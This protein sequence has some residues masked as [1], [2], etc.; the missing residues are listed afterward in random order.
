MSRTLILGLGNRLMT[1]DAVGLEALGA[2]R[3]KYGVPDGVDLMDGGT[4]GLDLLVHLEGY[5]RVLILDSVCTGRAPGD[6]VRVDG[7]AI[8]AVFADCLSPHQVGLQDLVAVLQLQ[9]RVPER[10]TVIGVE[11]ER[12]DP[13]LNLSAPVRAALP[14]MLEAAAGVLREWGLGVGGR[15]GA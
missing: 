4:L 12:I 5:P 1:D 9:G 8:G 13:G 11:P 6:V 10:L 7:D 2:F 14:R 3:A 15:P